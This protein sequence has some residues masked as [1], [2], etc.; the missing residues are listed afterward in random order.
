MKVSFGILV[1]LAPVMIAANQCRVGGE[2]GYFHEA[3]KK[4][5]MLQMK[6]HFD[7]SIKQLFLS[8]K[9]KSK[10][11]ERPGLAKVIRERSDAN[12]EE[13]LS[14]AKKFFQRGGHFNHT[15][16]EENFQFDGASPTHLE[17]SSDRVA[18]YSSALA[19]VVDDSTS[20][21]NTLHSE[22]ASHHCVRRDPD[23]AQFIQEKTANERETLREL[24]IIQ[25]NL[26]SL[27]TNG[28]ALHIFDGTLA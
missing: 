21:A 24:Q 6:K 15:A 11:M 19:G 1:V 23:M 10:S 9:M 7:T 20:T 4:L 14:Y 26:N 2:H 3:A 22:F 25:T 12:W 18:H 5:L 8:F 27:S 16:F 13:G 17:A 28:M